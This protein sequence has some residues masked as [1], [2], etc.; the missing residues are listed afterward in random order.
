M[1]ETDGLYLIYLEE[2]EALKIVPKTYLRFYC[3]LLGLL[4]IDFD[5]NFPRN[6]YSF[7]HSSNP[8]KNSNILQKEIKS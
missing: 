1:K 5:Y 4:Q 8:S 2:Y 7:F 3:S 6:E